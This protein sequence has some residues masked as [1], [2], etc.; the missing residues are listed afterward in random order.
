MRAKGNKGVTLVELLVVVAILSIVIS[1]IYAIFIS[2]MRSKF[3]QDQVV[4]MEQEMRA[5]MSMLANELRTAEAITNSVGAAF[6]PITISSTQICFTGQYDT[7]SNKDW[8]IYSYDSASGTLKRKTGD[9]SYTDPATVAFQPVATGITNVTF[10]YFDASDSP[11]NKDVLTG[12]MTTLNQDDV[13]DIRRVEIWLAAETARENPNTGKKLERTLRTS[14][15]L[16]GEKTWG[17]SG[18]GCG[19]LEMQI[20]RTD[21]S[22]CDGDTATLTAKL[23][24][25]EGH[26]EDGIVTLSATDLTFTPSNIINTTVSSSVTVSGPS[27]VPSGTYIE[28]V[29]AWKPASCSYDIITS[30]TIQV[31]AG[32]PYKIAQLGASTASLR[33]CSSQCPG[34]SSNITAKVED[35]CGNPVKDINV[36]FEVISGGGSFEGG[37]TI[38]NAVTDNEGKVTVTYYPPDYMG[39]ATSATAVVQASNTT[40]LTSTDPAD[41]TKTVDIALSPCD[42]THIVVTSKT[43]DPF[44]FEECPGEG[45]TLVSQVRDACENPISG[46]ES[47]LSA[48]LDPS[49]AGTLSSITEDPVGSGSYSL[50]YNTPAACGGGGL[51][52]ITI[53]HTAGISNAESVTLTECTLPNVSI[54]VSDLATNGDG[55][56]GIPAGCSDEAHQATVT[57]TVTVNGCVP[58]PTT[59]DVTFVVTSSGG[60]SNNGKWYENGQTSYTTT[61]DAPGIFIAHLMSDAARVG[62]VLTITAIANIPGYSASYSDT[63]QVDVIK[64]D[65]EVNFYTDNTYSTV[66]TYYDVPYVT[67]EE[68][69]SIYLQVVDCDEDADTRSTESISVTLESYDSTGIINTLTVTL[70]EADVDAGIFNGVIEMKRTEDIGVLYVN[71]GGEIIASYQDDDDTV[72]TASASVVLSGCKELKIVDS[73]GVELSEVTPDLEPYDSTYP[74]GPS[75]FHLIANIPAFS[76][77]GITNSVG[78]HTCSNGDND[79][80]NLAEDGDTGRLIINSAAH[81]R[82]YIYV[83]EGTSYPE[84]D[85]DGS[86]GI[87]V[88]SSPDTITIIYPDVSTTCDTNHDDVINFGCSATISVKD[89]DSPTVTLTPP[90]SPLSGTVSFSIDANDGTGTITDVSLYLRCISGSCTAGTVYTVKT[91]TPNA[92]SYSVTDSFD[93]S[94]YPDGSYAIY[95]EATDSRGNTGSSGETEITISNTCQFNPLTAARN[96]DDTVTV[97]GTFLLNGS[98]ASVRLSIL[99]SDGTTSDSF[100]ANDPDGSFSW[101]STKSFSGSTITVTV[102]GSH[103]SCSTTKVLTE[104]V[105]F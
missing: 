105:D 9:V 104:G 39:G 64:S 94:L 2:Q 41:T 62:D 46:E 1:L 70:N 32:Q 87:R 35:A 58:A 3:W 61:A 65:A 91:Y 57:A 30:R 12:E 33:T 68:T 11:M 85:G 5:S 101:T 14:V 86:V 4:A 96:M 38:T 81:T 83:G 59:A 8:V 60:W 92:S 22:F 26:P 36:D 49:T 102:D 82:D 80:V 18:S 103:G 16:R 95:A 97:S 19:I 93:S 63:Y 100:S 52:D 66:A 17:V 51:A 73:S 53:A 27:T 54:A 42:P 29:G 6:S 84:P 98:A 10:V 24:D 99:A 44:T 76:G 67:P 77:D 31:T 15:K 7:D 72:D 45:G 21:L 28:I 20:D 34:Q 48:T 75:A 69:G 13:D 71:K 88:T 74:D 40:D 78:I 79:S 56:T 23:W 43:P 55:E 37:V 90:P 89:I 50:V 25:L 47:N